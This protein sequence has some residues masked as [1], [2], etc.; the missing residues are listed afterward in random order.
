MSIKISII[1]IDGCGKSTLAA[2]LPNLVAAELGLPAAT[3]SDELRC[4][5]PD[6][7]LLLPGFA[8]DGKGC[9]ARIAQVLRRAADR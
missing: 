2:A 1:G 9:A 6:G 4:A 7:D 8:P 5:A 3:A